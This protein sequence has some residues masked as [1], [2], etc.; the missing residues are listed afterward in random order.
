MSNQ[1]GGEKMIAINITGE[2]YD[3]ICEALEQMDCLLQKKIKNCGSISKRKELKM[4][5]MDIEELFIVMAGEDDG[6]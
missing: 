3:T 1:I 6:I 2:Q 5:S 4:K